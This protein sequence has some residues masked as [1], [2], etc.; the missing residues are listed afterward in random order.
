MPVEVAAVAA[1]F[2]IHRHGSS[3]HGSSHQPTA[4]TAAN[5]SNSNG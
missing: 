5:S 1:G 3:K 2:P 4:E